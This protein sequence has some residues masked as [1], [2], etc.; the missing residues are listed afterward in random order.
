MLRDYTKTVRRA[1]SRY[2]R[3]MIDPIIM[4]A[5]EGEEMTGYGIMG[6]VHENFGVLLSPGTVYPKLKS[7]EQSGLIEQKTHG[8][9]KIYRLTERGRTLLVHLLSE[10]NSMHSKVA[11]LYEK[12]TVN[13]Y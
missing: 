4:A 12:A 13:R 9:C 1:R 6:F 11:V 2:V 10:Y 3:G 7:L 5:L 8:R